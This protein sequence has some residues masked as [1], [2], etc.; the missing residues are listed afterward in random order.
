MLHENEALHYPNY[1]SI[2]DVM[3]I[4]SYFRFIV[5][6]SVL[7][8]DDGRVSYPLCFIFVSPTGMSAVSLSYYLFPFT[9]KTNSLTNNHDVS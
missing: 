3:E 5:Y 9:S 2:F 7:N 1:S 8:H 6:S 4:L